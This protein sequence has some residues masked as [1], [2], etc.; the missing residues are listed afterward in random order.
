[1]DL[2]LQIFGFFILMSFLL[3]FYWNPMDCEV[4]SNVSKTQQEPGVR[5]I[6]DSCSSEIVLRGIYTQLH[7]TVACPSCNANLLISEGE[8]E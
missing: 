1:M 6:C 3:S 5:V 4:T 7:D 8:E 2:I